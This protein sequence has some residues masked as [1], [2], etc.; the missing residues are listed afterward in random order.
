MN[1]NGSVL[2]G[3]KVLEVGSWIAGP[4]AATIMSD[5]GAEVIKVEPPGAGDPYRGLGALPGMPV[6]EHNY[7]WLLDSRNKKSLALDVTRS[8]G[9][10]VLLRLAAQTDVFLTNFPLALLARLG[11]TWEDLSAVNPRLIYALLTAYG[12]VGQ[13]AAKPGYDVN[14]WWAR[15]GLMDLVRPAGAPP[16]SSM[17]GMGDH[18]TAV[19]LFGAIALGSTSASAPAG[20]RRSR[21][22]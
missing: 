13:E 21:R 16:T 17:P 19:A 10:D 3:I 2:N 4:A 20:A 7:S 22:P 1:T 14:A 6:S 9:R 8:E 15:S 12:E 5:F 18:P 11:L